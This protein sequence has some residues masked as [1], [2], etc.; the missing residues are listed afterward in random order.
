MILCCMCGIKIQ[1]NPVNMCVQCLKTRVDITEGITKQMSI[2]QCRNCHRY[3]RP[4]WVALDWEST[5]L[6]ALCLKKIKGLNKD[7]KLVDA[8]FIYTEQSSRRIRL[9]LTVQKEIM[10]G[11]IVQQ[12]FQVEFVIENQ[13]CE[14]CQKSFT[15]HTWVAVCQVRQKVPHQRT[16][17]YLE[18]LLLKHS[19]VDRAHSVKEMP[20]GLDFYWGSKSGAMHLLDFL[21]GV[22][23]IRSNQSKRLISADEH[24]NT[25][26]YKYTFY[27]E[28]APVCKD[29]L[30][31]IDAKLAAQLGGVTPLLLCHKVTASIHLLDPVSLK[32]V[33]IAAGLYWR[34]PFRSVMNCKQLVEY[35]VIDVEKVEDSQTLLA[36]NKQ[37]DRLNR[38]MA[39][40]KV[41][42]VKS[43]DMETGGEHQE[44]LSHLGN[45][46]RPGDTVLGYDTT[47]ANLQEYVKTL[48]SR[49]FPEVILVR[50][51]YPNRKNRS[52]QRNWR[53]KSMRKEVE[54]KTMKKSEV[55]AAAE[56]YEQ[57]MQDIEEDPEL[58]S[59]INLYKVKDEAKKAKKPTA[60]ATTATKAA[61]AAKAEAKKAAAA[62]SLME[63]EDDDATTT[64]A[65]AAVG[66]GV[67]GDDDDDDGFPSVEL[68]EL[69]EDM[70]LDESSPPDAA[71]VAPAAPAAAAGPA[72]AKP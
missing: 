36:F 55:Q 20:G 51:T 71:D 43:S 34:H 24:S 70:D 40:A 46:L 37:T 11:A 18:Q 28:I 22:V 65:A 61:A 57:F 1:P 59:T 52:R 39:L 38:K 4:P 6:L 8:G 32:L 62:A 15:E 23:P 21:Q 64:A 48:K 60:A 29:D 54:E 67:E 69:M 5:D 25:Y 53:L 72:P 31:V 47:H 13:Q 56:D 45:I 41:T 68:A 9:K 27:A 2:F 19:V 35:I 30:V 50:K 14:D 33:D 63:D 10:N 3:M 44:C 12:T 17:Y 26:N 16:F 7:V 66:E 58:R 49:A 42:C